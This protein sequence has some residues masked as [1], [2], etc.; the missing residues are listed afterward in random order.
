M[1]ASMLLAGKSFFGWDLLLMVSTRIVSAV[2]VAMVGVPL[3]AS[4][5]PFTFATFTQVN[6]KQ[7]HFAFVNSGRKLKRTEDAV[8]FSTPDRKRSGPVEVKFSFLQSGFHGL[9][10]NVLAKFQYDATIAKRSPAILSGMSFVQPGLAGTFSFTSEN[11]ITID[12]IS[13]ASGANLLSGVFSGGSL[14]GVLKQTAGTSDTSTTSGGMIT[15]SSAFLDFSNSAN[16]DI[17]LTLSSLNA[18][19][20]LQ[21]NHAL[22]S[23]R[24][25][26]GGQFSSDPAPRLKVAEPANAAVLLGG[27]AMLGFGMIRNSA[28][29]G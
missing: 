10:T 5:V 8:L 27:L 21:T 22:G 12:G 6:T 16:F 2:V 1:F 9:V 20:S 28:R 13:F 24:S 4:A 14:A 25:V 3:V 7:K 17:G 29:K 19:F 26:I 23:F 18:R 15:F 11:P